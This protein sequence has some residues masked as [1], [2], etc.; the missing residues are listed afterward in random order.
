M[1]STFILSLSVLLAASAAPFC[2]A[3]DAAPA[4]EDLPAT[5]AVSENS[6]QEREAVVAQLTSLLQDVEKNGETFEK[7]DQLG[8]LFLKVGDAQRAVLV[9]RKAIDDFGGTEALFS[10]YARVIEI[11]GSPEQTIEALSL[12]LESFPES[13]VLRFAIGKA[14]IAQGK[15][16]AAVSNLKKVL[17]LDPENEVYRFYLADAYR[18]QQKWSEASELIDGLIAEETELLQVY[19]MKGDLLLSQNRLEEGLNHLESVL[20]KN[21]DSEDAKKA[22]VQ[23]CQLFAYSEAEAGRVEEAVRSVRRSLE[24]LPDYAESLAALAALLNRLG[25][26]EEAETAFKRV[27]ELNPNNLDAHVFYGRMLE[28]LDRT[29]E[30]AVIYQKGLSKSRELGIKD[31]VETFRELLGIKLPN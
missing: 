5:D 30:A 29:P 1:K 4:A 16:Y 18:I 15:A 19:L 10:K 7:L 6:I 23:A 9:F 13:E 14:Y 3:Q 21:P 31:A 28:S 25:H 8:D 26:Y 22:T 24:I 12:G 17:A 20:E 11:A 2:S 27:I